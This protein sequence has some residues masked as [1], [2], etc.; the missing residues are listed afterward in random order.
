MSVDKWKLI[1][2]ERDKSFRIFNLRTDRA[3]SPRT[4]EEHDFYVFESP[5]WVNIIPVTKENE[6][7]LIR[8]YRHGIQ[9]VTLEIPGGIVEPGDTPL[10]GARRE[11]KEETGYAGRDMIY[12][13]MVHSNPAIFNN[14][15]HTYLALDCQPDGSQNLDDKE[16]IEV[17]LK[18]LEEIPGLI[19][20]GMISHSLILAAFYRYYMEYDR[21]RMTDDS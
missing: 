16:D 1:S 2:S 14:R 6:V 3:R 20:E 4:G 10:K 21:G 7:V 19:K 11:L 8:Q 17:V 18:Q 5:E 9:D 13:G 12:L 15:C